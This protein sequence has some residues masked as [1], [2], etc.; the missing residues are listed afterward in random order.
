MPILYLNFKV[1]LVEIE[2]NHLEQKQT[3]ATRSNY[4]TARPEESIN[5]VKD[6]YV[7][8]ENICRNISSRD[9]Y[10]KYTKHS[11]K[12]AAKLKTTCPQITHLKMG[13]WLNRRFPKVLNLIN[14]QRNTSQNHSITSHLFEWLLSKGQR[15]IL[16]GQDAEKVTS[17]VVC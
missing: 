14:H 7:M 1:A 2:I 12:A 11:H 17:T 8:G 6:A 4:M 3:R 13:K 10:P 5:T 15:Q 16:A 9:Q